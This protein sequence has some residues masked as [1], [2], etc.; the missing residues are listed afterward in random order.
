MGGQQDVSPAQPGPGDSLPW[1]ERSRYFDI[2][3]TNVLLTI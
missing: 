1:W 2:Q 3:Q